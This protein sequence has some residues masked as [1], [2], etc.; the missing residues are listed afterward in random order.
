MADS[1]LHRQ[2]K[3]KNPFTL[4]SILAPDP[5]SSLAQNL[6]LHG[7]ALDVI[8]AVT[9]DEAGRL[10]EIGERAREKA[11]KR[12]MY[13][14]REGGMFAVC[15]IYADSDTC[16]VIL[17]NSPLAATTSPAD[18]ERR[19]NS[20][21][22]RRALLKSNPSLYISKSRLSIRQIPLF[23]T[24]QMLKRLAIHAMRAFE[25]EVKEGKRDELTE[26][27]TRDPG[28]RPGDSDAVR[29]VAREADNETDASSVASS[30]S[31]S[32]TKSA[33]RKANF[34]QKLARTQRRG[35]SISG[36]KQA[37]IVRQAERVDVITGKGRSRGYGFVE[38]YTHAD[39]L[40]VLRWAN[41][42][43]DVDA[44]LRSW[45]SEELE[46]LIKIE[47]A[48]LK[49]EQKDEEEKSEARLK[50]MVTELAKEGKR[51]END[52]ARGRGTLI[53]EF[54]IEN[55][56]VV[57]RRKAVQKNSKSSSVRPQKQARSQDE[58]S[59]RPSKKRRTSKM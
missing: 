23:V 38:M 14:L 55:V 30:L 5:S 39:A 41:G 24:E 6:V 21:N 59:T 25:K 49:G 4:P 12:N 51:K 28:G 37:K 9:R 3:K 19:T 36:V 42:N 32:A 33:K 31:T 43:T 11:D 10:K 45:W 26:E 54:S 44:L 17:P 22:A 7:R 48:T 13:L 27:E 29:D 58:K 56:Q 2:P 34:L 57:Q 1:L 40:R 35:A 47:R 53:V 20:F 52:E 50:R 16:T 18:L 46:R 15:F 8:R